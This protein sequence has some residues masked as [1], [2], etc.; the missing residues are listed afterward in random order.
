[1]RSI[2]ICSRLSVLLFIFSGYAVTILISLRPSLAVGTADSGFAETIF[3][4]QTSSLAV[5]TADSVRTDSALPT[6]KRAIPIGI[7][8]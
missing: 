3:I 7:A 8:R 6:K 1:M 2:E 4:L 5:G